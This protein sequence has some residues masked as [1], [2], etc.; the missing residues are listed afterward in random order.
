MSADGSYETLTLD[1]N[2]YSVIA[3]NDMEAGETVGV[4]VKLTESASYL[5]AGMGLLFLVSIGLVY[6]FKEKLFRRR[7]ES[8]EELELEKIRIFQAI[9]GLGKHARTESSEE[10]NK[11]M[12]EYKQKA[13]RIFIKID[14]IKIK[15]KP[16]LFKK[17]DDNADLIKI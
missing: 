9:H 16:E 2:D 14:K 3:F 10:F 5:Y 17:M 7:R 8:F 13:I 12:D 15:D 6:H 1:G 4:E 11:L